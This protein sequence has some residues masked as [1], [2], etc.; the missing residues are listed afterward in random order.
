M[1]LMNAHMRVTRSTARRGSAVLEFA[2][3]ASFLMPLFVGG[4]VIGINLSR[5]IQATQISRDLGHMY[6]RQVDLSGANG[7]NLAVRLATG[8]GITANGGNGVI[9]L[10][11]VLKVSQSECDG[12]SLTAA[13][14]TNLNRSV[15][16]NRIVIGA[17]GLR[18]SAVGTPTGT[19]D[20]Q[21]GV[22]NYLT[23]ITARTAN[24]ETILALT[25]GEVAYVSEVY[26]NS[27]DLNFQQYQTN[28]GVY[29]RSIF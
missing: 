5:S 4:C 22:P 28:T 24:F 10:S 16:V 18:S 11:K 2:L 8:T 17:A 20:S 6:A 1:K 13:Q 26:V 9:I 29:A 23:D 19:L 25:G 21:G 15:I 7:K 27:P 12:A 14:C 3:V